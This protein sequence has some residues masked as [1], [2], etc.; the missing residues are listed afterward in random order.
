MPSATLQTHYFPTLP[1]SFHTHHTH[2]PSHLCLAMHCH[3][4]SF[5]SYQPPSSCHNPVTPSHSLVHLISYTM[6]TTI[7]H[8][9]KHNSQTNHPP[10]FLTSTS[11]QPWSIGSTQD[12]TIPILYT[13]RIDHHTTFSLSLYD[14]L[15]TIFNLFP[16]PYPSY[17]HFEVISARPIR[18]EE[19]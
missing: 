5:Q 9:T 15:T 7:F 18:I 12:D 1:H 11:W 2:H 10:N 16:T 6:L 4:N 8:T 14:K 19:A 17:T 13:H 3:S